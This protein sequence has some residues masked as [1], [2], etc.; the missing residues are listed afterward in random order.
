MLKEYKGEL[1]FLAIAILLAFF[2]GHFKLKTSLF[3]I[4]LLTP[5]SVANQGVPFRSNNISLILFD[6]IDFRPLSLDC[7]FAKSCW[8]SKNPYIK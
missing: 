1:L 2:I 8:E 5:L 7:I 6:P 3:S 4:S